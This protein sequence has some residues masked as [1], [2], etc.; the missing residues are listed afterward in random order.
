ML[1]EI[2]IKI[3]HSKLGPFLVKFGIRKWTFARELYGSLTKIKVD[4]PLNLDGFKIF[5]DSNDSLELLRKK[6]FYENNKEVEIMKKIV[7]KGDI[8]LDIGANI[9]IYSLLLA[10]LVG[11][12]GKVYSFEPDP[13][14]FDTL[15]KNIKINRYENIIAINKA[16]S[17]KTGKIKLYLAEWNKGD[18]RIY[19][20]DEKRKFLE[21]EAVNLDNYFKDNNED[22]KF[23]KIDIQGAEPL[24]FEGG[25]LFFKNKKPIVLQEFW[26]V[27]INASGEDLKKFL[28]FLASNYKIYSENNAKIE[29]KPKDILSLVSIKKRN[30]TNL[31][32]IP[33][34]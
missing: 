25:Q 13:Q 3:K 20:S 27:G 4:K 22:I 29:I 19:P 23:V 31:L 9:G 17:K 6:N 12:T 18:H 21:I 1:R 28:D 7:K 14:N 16:I 26:P 8:V 24:L 32:C 10:K 34:R 15:L 11:E 5:I 30:H 2:A 33:K